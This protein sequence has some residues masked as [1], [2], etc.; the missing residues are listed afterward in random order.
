M[1]L[2]G[3]AQHTSSL[4][5]PHVT[6]CACIYTIEM[7]AET[8]GISITPARHMKNLSSDDR[9]LIVAADGKLLFVQR[10][11]YQLEIWTRQEDGSPGMWLRTMVVMLESPRETMTHLTIWG[12]KG[13]MLPVKNNHGDR[14]RNVYT[15]H[16]QARVMEKLTYL[17]NI[18]VGRLCPLDGLTNILLLSSRYVNFPPRNYPHDFFLLNYYLVNYCVFFG[19][20]PTTGRFFSK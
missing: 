9:Q 13:G 5:T 12:E 11:S 2:C 7:D 10:Q 15:L 8:C 14:H 17:D 19:Q 20:T 6:A 16:L 18:T 3:V 4:D 1:P